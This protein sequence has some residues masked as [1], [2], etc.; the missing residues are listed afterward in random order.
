MVSGTAAVSALK[1]VSQRVSCGTGVRAT[2]LT[3]FDDDLVHETVGLRIVWHTCPP[4]PSGSSIN[5]P[6]T[7]TASARFTTPD[8]VR[9]RSPSPLLKPRDPL[10]VTVCSMLT[11][12]SLE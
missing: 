12:L 6:S 9:N 3:V 5:F 7:V 4:P 11:A 10:V 2:R 1:G 8:S